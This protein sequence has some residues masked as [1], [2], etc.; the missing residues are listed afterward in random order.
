MTD[1]FFR[2]Q[3]FDRLQALRKRAKGQG[4][5]LTDAE[6]EELRQLIAQEFRA[7]IARTSIATQHDI[8]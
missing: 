5:P 6:Q 8:A 2:Q 3:D 7:T 4:A 1:R